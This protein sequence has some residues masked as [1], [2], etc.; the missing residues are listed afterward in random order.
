M[1]P[2][3]RRIPT[4]FRARGGGPVAANDPGRDP[5]PPEDSGGDGGGPGPKGSR[6]RRL[7]LLGLV[8]I[9]GVA[10]LL[11]VWEIRTSR[12]QAHF[13]APIAADLTWSVE[14]GPAEVDFPS[15]DGPY[16]RRLG[17]AFLPEMIASAEGRGFRIVEQARVSPRF[18]QVV[19]DW[20]IF[21]VFRGKA[22]AGLAILD[23]SGE[24][25]FESPYPSRVYPS[26]EAIPA[27]V[28]EALLFIENRTAL[29]PDR[30]YK[31]PAVEWTRLLRSTFELGGRK[32]TGGDGNV[33]GASTLATQI[34]KFRHAPDG[35]TMSPRDKLVQMASASLRG[36]LGGPETLA[37]RQ[38]IVLEY[39]NSV[40]LAAQR[41]EGEVTGIGDGLWAWYGRDFEEANL[42]LH[43]LD[44][45]GTETEEGAAAFREVLSL[46]LSQRRPSY[47]LSQA[48]GREELALLTDQ[49]IELMAGEGVISPSLA[50]S[51]HSART[52][53]LNLP[54]EREPVDF[55]ERKGVNA[56]RTQLLGLLGVPS[57]YELDKL[58]L[59]VRTTIDAGAQATATR[60]IQDLT[61]PEFVQARGLTGSNLLGAGDP[62][63][64]VYSLVL[65]EVTP[66]GNLVRVQTDNLDAPFN[67]NESARLELGSTAKLRTLASYL[68]VIGESFDRFAPLT[69]DSLRNFSI[70]PRDRLAVWAR[71]QILAEPW[72][73]RLEILQRAMERTYSANPAERFVTGGGTQTFSNFDNTYDYSTISVTVAFRQSVNLVFVRMMRDIVNYYIYRVPGSTAHVL[74]DTNDPLRQEYLERFADR[75][76]IQFLDQFYPKYQGRTRTEILNILIGEE[77]RLSPQRVA[78]AYRAVVPNGSLA[79]FDPL[80]RANQPEAAFVGATIEDLYLRANPVG[81]NLADLGYLSSVHPLELWVARFLIENPEGTRSDVISASTD[82]RQEVYRWLFRTSRQ[83]AQDQRIRSL[84]EVEAFTHIHEGWKRFGYPFEN[85]V[86]SLGSSIGSSGDRPSALSDMVGII[87]NDG[88]RLPT[89]RVEELHFATGTPFE[90]MMVREGRTGEQVTS[91]EVA[92]VLREAMT[93]VVENGTAR[94]VAGAF[95]TPDGTLLTVGGKTGTG[96]NRYRTFSPGG[97]LLESRSVNRTSTFVFF[98]GDRFYG[99]VTA[100]VPGEDADDYT[101]TSALPSQILRELAPMVEELVRDAEADLVPEEASS[102]SDEASADPAEPS[103][104]GD[105]A[106]PADE[107]SSPAP[108]PVELPAEDEGSPPSLEEESPIEDAE[109][110]PAASP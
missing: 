12:L 49:Y 3:R 22:Q 75:E 108:A 77:R 28:V 32:I 94:R 17:Y 46:M 19:A 15:A 93:D 56:V 55:V 48:A 79:E 81:Q 40:P 86:P 78:R 43:S 26:F 73:T 54:P 85:I 62:A 21:P 50:E 11:L 105:P 106:P 41:I 91:V 104:E 47:Y 14:E 18:R 59:Q 99:V 109:P 27:I 35:L 107:A 101:F 103:G 44:E 95:R 23:R 83:S 84:L 97:R 57:L 63:R 30:P 8:V 64:V 72:M 68:E 58:D 31:N 100:Y 1:T 2:A 36:Y 110:S 67:L 80:L 10:T 39:L 65:H 20:G 24:P 4:L 90:T 61:T 102:P 9:L 89:Y 38:E 29:D 88:V 98:I 42:A 5:H 45:G 71:D 37:A 13:L 69:P 53:I 7:L 66:R 60:F 82:A 52:S 74:D 33:A 70:S 51:A 96:D 34:Q 87:L 6:W 16:D 76:G 25:Y 92:Q